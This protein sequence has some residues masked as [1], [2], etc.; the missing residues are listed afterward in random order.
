MNA[1][2]RQAPIFVCSHIRGSI[3]K[4]VPSPCPYSER[5]PAN[6]AGTAKRT[7]VLC[8]FTSENKE[9]KTNRHLN[10]NCRPF[11]AIFIREISSEKKL[12]ISLVFTGI[13]R[14]LIPNTGTLARCFEKNRSWWLAFVVSCILFFHHFQSPAPWFAAN[15]RIF[16]I[17]RGWGCLSR[18][19]LSFISAVPRL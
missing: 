3:T 8:D 9:E 2:P 12:R 4:N 6:Q 17:R 13:S 7:W 16:G 19:Y 18:L 11:F 15:G 14:V 5:A 10:P 1:Q